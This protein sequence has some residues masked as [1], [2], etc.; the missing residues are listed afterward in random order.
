MLQNGYAQMQRLLALADRPTAV[1]CHNDMIAIGAE[2]AV[3]EQGLRIPADMALIGFDAL[4][5]SAYA[6]VP[7]T[8]VDP[9]LERMVT[10]LT[11]TM[12]ACIEKPDSCRL[13]I[14]HRMVPELVVRGSTGAPASAAAIKIDGGLRVHR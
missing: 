10:R 7:L 2:R 9:H 4:R 13:P 12:I 3:L 1:L 14:Q 8:S 6:A 11:E 5:E